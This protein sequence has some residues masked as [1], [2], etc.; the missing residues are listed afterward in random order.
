MFL[1]PVKAVESVEG[2]ATP[3]FISVM[4]SFGTVGIC[5]KCVKHHLGNLEK[6][7][8]YKLQIHFPLCKVEGLPETYLKGDEPIKPS[9]YVLVVEACIRDQSLQLQFWLE[10][11]TKDS[12]SQLT[13]D[14]GLYSTP[15]A[16]DLEKMT[17][18]SCRVTLVKHENDGGKL[19]RFSQ[20]A[21]SFVGNPTQSQDAV[22]AQIEFIGPETPYTSAMARAA[23]IKA[24]ALRRGSEV[25]S[26]PDE[27]VSFLYLNPPTVCR[28][29]AAHDNPQITDLSN[30]DTCRPTK[31]GDEMAARKFEED[32][33]SMHTMARSESSS[34]KTFQESLEKAFPA[35]IGIQRGVVRTV[36][37]LHMECAIDDLANPQLR[38]LLE[39]SIRY[40]DINRRLF[41]NWK[42]A[43][44]WK[45]PSLY[46]FRD[47]ERKST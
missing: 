9:N 21:Y 25:A 27:E 2:Y 15:H 46:R 13:Y 24:E 12:K 4:H 40:E 29:I 32:L 38:S 43:C 30:D 23:A 8:S 37:K 17:H 35:V 18:L 34:Q 11:K 7:C 39:H 22:Q 26:V 33:Q 31:S 3:V 6:N 19:M 42:H 45:N 47:A 36:P 5:F 16:S 14:L 20:W 1:W 44:G 10:E 41:Q 28:I